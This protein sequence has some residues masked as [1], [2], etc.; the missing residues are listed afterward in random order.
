M[1][2]ALLG[3]ASPS[4]ATEADRNH[5]HPV[6]DPSVFPQLQEYAG[7]TCLGTEPTQAQDTFPPQDF[8]RP[9]RA[10]PRA[11]ELTAN[12]ALASFLPDVMEHSR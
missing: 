12:A 6:P 5:P 3:E 2:S 1:K 8:P 10:E 7:I 9:E 11:Q 4:R